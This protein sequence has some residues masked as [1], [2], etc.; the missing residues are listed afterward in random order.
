M[1]TNKKLIILSLALLLC[2]TIGGTLAFSTSVEDDTN[3]FTTSRVDIQQLEYE[4]GN[5]SLKKFTQEQEIKPAY[6]VNDKIEYNNIPQQWDEI[7]V[8]SENILYSDSIK[9]VI[10]KF[11]F[12]KNIGKTDAYYRTI[13][14]FECPNGF[15]K[16]LIQINKNENNKFNWKEIGYVNLGTTRYYLISATYNHILEPNETSIPSL[17]QVFLDPK[18]TNEHMDL[19]GETFDILVKTQSA[20]S[21]DDQTAEQVLNKVFGNTTSDNINKWFD[22]RPKYDVTNYTELTKAIDEINED[23]IINVKDEI[24]DNKAGFY[25][26]SGKKF[27]INGNDYKVYMGGANSFGYSMNIVNNAYVVFN[28]VNIDGGG[29]QIAYDSTVEFNGG[30]IKISNETTNPRYTVYAVSSGTEVTINGGDFSFD[31]TKKRAYIYAGSGTKVYINGGNFGK[32]SSR[33]DYNA[34]TGE[35]INYSL[36]I[37]GPGTVIIKGGTFGFN[38]TTWVADGYQAMKSGSTWTVV[39]E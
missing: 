15:D 29:F 28:D 5:N 21:V 17:L 38:P 11:V 35:G 3:V 1:N 2:I 20:Q 6:Y 23:S 12:I 13:I 36:G 7:G 30:S 27:D 4:R 31:T 19:L 22:L 24:N 39:P 26:I 16:S 10:D 32:A 37:V 33:N 14:A 18:T 8:D 9:N 34:S 25:E